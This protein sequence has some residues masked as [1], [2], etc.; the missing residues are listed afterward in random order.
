MTRQTMI[1]G[2]VLVHVTKTASSED[3]NA[4]TIGVG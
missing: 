3:R 4:M 2:K 1:M